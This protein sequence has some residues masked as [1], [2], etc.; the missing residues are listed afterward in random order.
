MKLRNKSAFTLLE[1]A[2]VIAIIAVIIAVSL[3]A[4]QTQLESV[5][6]KNT[7]DRLNTIKN[8]LDTYF[9]TNNRYPCPAAGNIVPGAANHGVEAV[10]CSPSACP[11]GMVCGTRSARGTIPF[12]TLGLSEQFAQD[13]WLFSMSYAVDNLFTQAN[14][15]CESGG[16]LQIVDYENNSVSTKA[17]FALISHGKDGAG[18]YVTQTGTLTTCNTG[19]RDGENCDTDDIFKTSPVKTNAQTAADNFDDIVVWGANPN[20]KTCPAGL[21]DCRLWLDASDRC[22][23]TLNGTEV[24]EWRNKSAYSYAAVEANASIQPTYQTASGSLI[25]NRP[26]IFFNYGDFMYIQDGAG[27]DSVSAF[28]DTEL[29]RV[30]VYRTSFGAG[31]IVGMTDSPS[32]F[33]GAFERMFYMNAGRAEHYLWNGS[34]ENLISSNTYTDNLPHIFIAS[35]GSTNPHK[36]WVDGN[37]VASGTFTFSAFNWKTNVIIGGHSSNNYIQGNVLEILY[38]DYVLSNEERKLLENYMADKWGI[39][40]S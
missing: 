4:Y 8:A 37:L 23:I 21:R 14:G 13:P 33:A 18:S 3:S 19:N 7:E 5:E 31:M 24:A 2:V 40:L 9:K 32:Y 11:A 30:V 26:N 35:A 16:A 1:M 27:Y 36:L 10:A 17:V 39:A 29:T 20:F 34:T 6:I 12:V 15:N 28:S 22:T 38:F 25:N